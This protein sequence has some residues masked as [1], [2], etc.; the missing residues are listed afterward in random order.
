M[1]NIGSLELLEHR[2]D[3][4]LRDPF[5]VRIARTIMEQIEYL[6]P[7]ALT[8]WGFEW[9]EVLPKANITKNGV[10]FFTCMGG[11]GF[12]INPEPNKMPSEY[13]IKVVSL[14]SKLL[15]VS[16]MKTEV[17]EDGVQLYVEKE[18]AQDLHWGKLVER[19]NA[20]IYRNAWQ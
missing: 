8:R 9:F 11:C 16:I 12:S 19:I 18:I 10:P 1:K 14:P 15:R 20:L 6:D 3:Q 17:R 13:L 4:A 7:T 5:Q 2:F